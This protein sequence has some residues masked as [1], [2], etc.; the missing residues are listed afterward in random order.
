MYLGVNKSTSAIKKKASKVFLSIYLTGS[1]PPFEKG[2]HLI[3][4]LIKR[5]KP[6]TKP[7]FSKASIA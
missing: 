7:F 5:K 1:C 3:I 4:L 6:T 2:L